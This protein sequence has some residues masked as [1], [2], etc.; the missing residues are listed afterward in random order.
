MCVELPLS[1]VLPCG[2]FAVCYPMAGLPWEQLPT[3]FGVTMLN[4]E[5]PAG[6]ADVAR[7]SAPQGAGPMGRRAGR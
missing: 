2:F 7:P 1:A 3:L 4:V 5:A 6:V